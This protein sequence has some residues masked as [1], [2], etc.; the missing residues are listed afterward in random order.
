MSLASLSLLLAAVQFAPLQPISQ[1]LTLLAGTVTGDF[2]GDGDVDLIAL[3]RFEDRSLYFEAVTPGDFAAP[4]LLTLWGATVRGAVS[5]DFTGDGQ[6][7]LVIVTQPGDQRLLLLEGHGDGT[8]AAPVVLGASLTI[9]EN[10]RLID[11]NQDGRL[12]ILAT[13]RGLFGSRPTLFQNLGG[14]TFA[15]PRP[16][17]GDFSNDAQALDLD[18]DGDLDLLVASMGLGLR[19][20]LNDGTEHFQFAGDLSF[21]GIDQVELMDL[22]GDGDQDAIAKQPFG[23]VILAFENLGGGAFGPLHEYLPGT[24]AISRFAIVDVDRDGREDV[25]VFSNNDLPPVW[26]RNEAGFLLGSAQTLLSTFTLPARVVEVVDLNADDILDFVV[27]SGPETVLAIVSDTALGTVPYG[28]AGGILTAVPGMTDVTAIDIDADGDLDLVSVAESGELYLAKGRGLTQ[29]DVP[30]PLGLTAGNQLQAAD[31]DDDGDLD[32]V[33]VDAERRVVL[34]ENSGGGGLVE[35]VLTPGAMT[36]SQRLELGDMNGDGLLDI[37]GIGDDSEIVLVTQIS[38]GSFL[39][40]NSVATFNGFVRRV[41]VTDVNQD[42]LLDIATT[43]EGSTAGG[44]TPPRRLAWLQG[45]TT[46]GFAPPEPLIPNTDSLIRPLPF[47]LNAQGFVEFLW[48][49]RTNRSSLIGVSSAPSTYTVTDLG[50][51]PGGSNARFAIGDLRGSGAGDLVVAG[52]PSGG[53]AFQTV[54]AYSRNGSSFNQLEGILATTVRDV[55]SVRFLDLDG[56]RDEDILLASGAAPQLAWIENLRSGTI[57]TN[58]CGPAVQNSQGLSATMSAVGSDLASSNDL[59]LRA[60]NLTPNVTSVFIVSQ[61]PDFVPIVPGSL[62]TLC[63]GGAIGRYQGSGQVQTASVDGTIFLDLEL[64]AIP[65]PGGA[66]PALAGTLW[67]F[68][69]WYRDSVAGQSTS[70]F[71]DGLAVV[72]S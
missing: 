66:V 38:D 11:L 70:N 60:E 1:P 39:P 40:P 9:N 56:D 34:F 65:Q 55:R 17:F 25:A 67:L 45:L 26:L 37:V 62:G 14:G 59:T 32:I 54:R 57:G 20:L 16:L 48:M 69:A 13:G 58:F 53:D 51:D 12:D 19:V 22:D 24:V 7:D 47:Q 3:D 2:D 71:S 23:S 36:F 10:P 35:R 8:F 41:M 52:G 27:G 44:F 46:G 61:T 49:S 4:R 63:L 50:V 42:G 72:F 15:P 31:L 18:D 6:L 28:P 68:Q 5:A 29:R 30:A 21:P 33:A 43:S 64:S